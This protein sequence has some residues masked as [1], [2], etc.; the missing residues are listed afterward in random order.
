LRYHREHRKGKLRL[1]ENKALAVSKKK[2]NRKG[3]ATEAELARRNRQSDKEL[4]MPK[5]EP[6]EDEDLTTS[7]EYEDK[8]TEE[9][10]RGE[11]GAANVYATLA[12]AATLRESIFILAEILDPG[13]D[14]DD[15]EPT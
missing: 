3:T 7:E 15:D 14:D 1:P 10:N 9:L 2:K 8:A 6:E 4:Y 5:E 12:L 13:E 11:A